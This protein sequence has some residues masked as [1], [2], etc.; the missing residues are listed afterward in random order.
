MTR[1]DAM[2][3][4]NGQYD[5]APG[6]IAAIVTWLEMRAPPPRRPDPPDAPYALRHVGHPD[7]AWFRDLFRRIGEDWLWVSRLML[8]DAKL[9]EVIHDPNLE[10][11]AL[12]V[13]G[14]AEGL[15]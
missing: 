1:G 8:S 4:P 11:H 15:L 5:L 7:L 14:R 10:V 9:A 3:L 13:N 2:R 6:T 12:E